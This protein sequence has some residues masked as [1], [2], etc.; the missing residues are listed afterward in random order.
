MAQHTSLELVIGIAIR[1]SGVAVRTLAPEH[2][3]N[4]RFL[5]RIIQCEG[6][7]RSGK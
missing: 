4:E 1:L 7:L 5:A 6:F 2:D 3:T